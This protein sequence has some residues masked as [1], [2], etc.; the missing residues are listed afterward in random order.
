M[1]DGVVLWDRFGGGGRQKNGLRLMVV[2]GE[3]GLAVV[4]NEGDVA[5]FQR[6]KL[7]KKAI[8][9]FKAEFLPLVRIHTMKKSPPRVMGN[10]LQ[11]GEQG[12][13]VGLE[14]CYTNE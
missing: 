11:Y 12:V 8:V 5:F 2:A 6:T 3:N 10:F 1:E 14:H 7:Q 9:L 13:G 4:E